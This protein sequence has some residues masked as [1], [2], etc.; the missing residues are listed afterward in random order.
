MKFK[1]N[2]RVWAVPALLLAVS[3]TFFVLNPTRRIDRLFLYQ[4]PRTDSVVIERHRTIWGDSRQQNMCSFV[5][6]QLLPPIQVGLRPLIISD[7]PDLCI[8]RR[9]RLY[10]NFTRTF[11]GV[12]I[13]SHDV[14]T[15]ADLLRRA[16][17]TNFRLWR[18]HISL[19]GIPLE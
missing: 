9:G 14:V 7:P 8:Y 17:R 2:I 13:A 19:E 18:I 15:Q 1:D 6:E 12:E 5:E 3:L 16:I 11:G 10:L 4:H